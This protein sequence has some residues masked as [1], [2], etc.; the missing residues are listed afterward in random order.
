MLNKKSTYLTFASRENGGGATFLYSSHRVQQKSLATVHEPVVRV[1]TV[2]RKPT[3]YGP[4][5]PKTQW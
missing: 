5:G 3:D 1:A 4:L 2:E